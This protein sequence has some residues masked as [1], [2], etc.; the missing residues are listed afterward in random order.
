MTL[1]V[2]KLDLGLDVLC[3]QDLV[4][5][6][7][8]DLTAGAE[9]VGA[10]VGPSAGVDTPAAVLVGMLQSFFDVEAAHEN[11]LAA[12]FAQ[13]G[14]LGLRVPSALWGDVVV[15]QDATQLL[16][17]VFAGAF[18][19]EADDE[20]LGWVVVEELVDL[21]HQITEVFV[22]RQRDGEDTV[23]QSQIVLFRF[24]RV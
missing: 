7:D 23:H 17:G 21:V 15:A 3:L 12:D 6:L 16:I 4:E 11:D 18:A 24:F 13:G 20:C 22:A 14:D 10:V 5:I 2:H 19:L 8:A 1:L 9:G